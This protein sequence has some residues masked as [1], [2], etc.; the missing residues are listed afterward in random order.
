MSAALLLPVM[1]AGSGN[2]YHDEKG[3]FASADA[4][5]APVAAPV[6]GSLFTKPDDAQTARIQAVL[7]RHD[8]DPEVQKLRAKIESRGDARNDAGVMEG[9]HYSAWAD[10]ENQTIAQSFLNPA[11]KP[12][13]GEP[14]IATFMVGLPGSGKTSVR[15]S[16]VSLPPSV[17]VNSDLIMEKIP[18]Y[19]P[20][21]ANAYHER[22]S[23]IAKNYLM[24][25]VIKGGYH[26]V[27]DTTNNV[28]KLTHQIQTVKSLGY[29]VG[30]I[31]ARVDNATSVERVY[32]RWKGGDRYVP[33]RVALSYGDRPAKTFE[34]VKPLA[35]Q[36]REYDTTGRSPQK[37][38]EGGGG[39]FK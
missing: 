12:A 37:T 27:S 29:K 24:P 18:G 21:L 11:A 15:N 13:S 28:D 4:S 38:A 2:P 19:E 1:K 35:D 36:W 39:L 22:A 25:A 20:G 33:P 7:D 6:Q 30:V 32:T 3:L 17:D 23:D 9:D 16:G 14:P 26:F 5:G 34:A 10:K 8:N 31:H